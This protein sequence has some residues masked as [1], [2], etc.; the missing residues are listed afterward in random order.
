VAL[1]IRDGVISSAGWPPAEWATVPWRLPAVEDALRGRPPSPGLWTDAVAHGRRRR[2]ALAGNGFSRAVAAHPGPAAGH[3]RGGHGL[4]ADPAGP[5]A[6]GTDAPWASRCP[7]VDGRLQGHR[8]ATYGREHT[9]PI[10]CT[11]CS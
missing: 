6:P 8:R 5:D 2:E 4:M 7:A 11:P 3:G 10:C 1:D 9:C